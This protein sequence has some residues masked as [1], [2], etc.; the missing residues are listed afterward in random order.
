M[1]ELSSALGKM[2]ESLLPFRHW[3]RTR[4]GVLLERVTVTGSEMVAV[5]RQILFERLLYSYKINAQNL[6]I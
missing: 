4:K 5:S 3:S 1:V 2:R 6:K